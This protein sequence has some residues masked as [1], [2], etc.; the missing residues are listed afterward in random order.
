M[1]HLS[2]MLVALLSISLARAAPPIEAYGE[3]P[4]IRSIDL[5]PSGKYV[6][7]IAYKDGLEA[8]LVHELGVGPVGGMR[9]DNIK[10]RSVSFADD[11]YV[12]LRASDTRNIV[13]YVRS[14]LEYTGAYSYDI[15]SGRAVQLLRNTDEVYP[16]QSG[17]GRIVGVHGDGGRIFMP[18]YTFAAGENPDYNLLSVD[19]SNG[20]GVIHAR[21]GGDTIDWFV[22]RDGVV[23]A[24]ED[25]DNGGNKHTI[26]TQRRG[27][28]ETVLETKSDEIPFYLMGVAPDQR[29]LIMVD[30]TKGENFSQLYEL[31]FEGRLSAPIFS[32]P[33]A[34]IR[35]VFLDIQREMSGVSYTGFYPEYEFFDGSITQTMA[36][37]QAYF[38]DNAVSLASTTDN[39]DKLLLFVSGS[40]YSGSYFLYDRNESTLSQIAESRPQIPAS[41]IGRVLPFRYPAR[42]GLQIP[43]ILTSPP[44]VEPKKLPL[45]VM[46]HGGP[47]DYDAVGFD[48]MAQF[49]AN[50]GYLVFQPNFRG[51]AGFGVRFRDAGHGEWGG[52]MQDDITDGVRFLIDSG[53]ADPDR[54]C[55]VGASY[56]G[57]AALA[58]GAFTPE[59]Y[60][61]VAAIAPV[62]DLPAMLIDERRD[63]GSDH[64]AIQYWTKFIGD[65]KSERAKLEAISPVNHAAA[66]RAPVLLIHGKDDLVVP[67]RHSARM[68]R[69]LNSENKSVE[70]IQLAGEDHWLSTGETRLE[71]L[72]ALDAFVSAHIGAQ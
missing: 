66:F 60:K 64:W 15:E 6:G 27:R 56:G 28:W 44:G 71:T 45:I 70:L 12:I 23:L 54:V 4:E 37:L 63:Y 22:S 68:E 9:T 47:E 69:A 20:R 72:K 3:L 35:G 29:A 8:L 52:K 1:K 13:G 2:A 14:R 49:F 39:N 57:Y 38:G 59:L 34:S 24:R 50:R 61:C 17:L 10:A 43:A 26:R 40:D 18:A 46:P 11:R 53:R 51:S 42:D 25:Y 67:M 58:G 41:E 36:E 62:S 5:S 7:F 33:D 48:W 21:G 65:L 55:I 16:A 31:S 19:L 30:E 32:R